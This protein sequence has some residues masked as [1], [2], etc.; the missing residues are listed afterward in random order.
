MFNESM[1]IKRAIVRGKLE[2]EN[3]KILDYLRNMIKDSDFELYYGGQ[4]KYSY[5]VVLE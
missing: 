5:Y 1:S 3:R 2:K 4:D